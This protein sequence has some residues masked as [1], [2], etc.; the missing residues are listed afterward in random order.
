MERGGMGRIES[1]AVRKEYLEMRNEGALFH[2]LSGGRHG[3]LSM[4][5]TFGFNQQI[6]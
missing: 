4:L 2:G 6:G 1:H 3:E 5:D